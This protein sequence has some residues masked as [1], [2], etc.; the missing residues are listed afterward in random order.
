MKQQ[1]QRR[2]VKIINAKLKEIHADWRILN[3]E[4][5]LSLIKRIDLLNALESMEDFLFE[6]K[7]EIE[8]DDV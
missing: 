8:K 4:V 5:K 7:K 3:S 2:L 1:L 6:L